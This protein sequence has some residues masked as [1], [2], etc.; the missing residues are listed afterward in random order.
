MLEE[1]CP[2]VMKE[3]PDL[4]APQRRNA[5]G[6]PFPAGTNNPPE[7]PSLMKVILDCLPCPVETNAQTAFSILNQANSQP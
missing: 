5:I 2:P 6:L 1:D 7:C 3:I 4:Y